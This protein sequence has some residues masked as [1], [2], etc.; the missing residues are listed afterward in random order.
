VTAHDVILPEAALNA[1]QS[2]PEGSGPSA[3]PDAISE[4]ENNKEVTT[5]D[6]NSTGSLLGNRAI[7]LSATLAVAVGMFIVWYRMAQPMAAA[8]GTGM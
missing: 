3:L 7:L 5:T 6:V 1:K 4:S 2:S 8:Q